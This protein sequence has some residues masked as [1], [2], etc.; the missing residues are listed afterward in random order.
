M[1]LCE[2]VCFCMQELLATATVTY[3]MYM[4][5]HNTQYN[6]YLCESHQLKHLKR[7]GN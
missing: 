6:L 3:I 4:Y 2:L 7:F 5:K 1:K